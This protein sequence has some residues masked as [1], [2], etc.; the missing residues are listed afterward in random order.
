MRSMSKEQI[1]KKIDNEQRKAARPFFDVIKLYEWFNS[2][3][4]T[5]EYGKG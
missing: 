3:V 4:Q 2:A 1:E 5:V